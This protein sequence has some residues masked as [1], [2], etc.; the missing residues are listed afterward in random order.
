MTAEVLADQIEQLKQQILDKEKSIS[1]FNQQIS[2]QIVRNGEVNS[3]VEELSGQLTGMVRRRRQNEEIYIQQR[4]SQIPM[5]KDQMVDIEART[6]HAWNRLKVI[7]ESE[8]PAPVDLDN[9]HHEEQ[10]PPRSTEV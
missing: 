2:A 9:L 6:R 4:M 8:S 3:E 1:I 10:L 7:A 5:I